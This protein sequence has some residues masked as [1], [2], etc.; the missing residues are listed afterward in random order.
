MTPNLGN[1]GSPSFVASI[2]HLQMTLQVVKTDPDGL[3]RYTNA[4]GR[5]Q[6]LQPIRSECDSIA[7]Y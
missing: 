1:C 5:H 4:F 7:G 6:L 3:C 2:S